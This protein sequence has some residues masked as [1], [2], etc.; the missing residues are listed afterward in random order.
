MTQHSAANNTISA[1]RHSKFDHALMARIP[2]SW[3][4]LISVAAKSLSTTPSQYVREAIAVSLAQDGLNTTPPQQEFA[5]VC[6]GALV[7]GP[8]GN[9]IKTHWPTP[10]ADCE[11]TAIEVDV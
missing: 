7:S 9:V 11:W 5:L 1:P 10:I 4:A 2:K 8:A 3:A 6:N